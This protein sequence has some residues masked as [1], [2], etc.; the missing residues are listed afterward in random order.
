MDRRTFLKGILA[1][2]TAPAIVKADNLMNI[3]VPPRERIS[4]REVMVRS[5]GVTLQPYQEN[6]YRWVC[7]DEVG[8]HLR[9][10]YRQTGQARA[11]DED[12][13]EFQMSAPHKGGMYR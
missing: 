5:S 2:A 4:L 6:M 1:T 8:L 7:D 12:N 10:G 13:F 11:F 9:A 3:W